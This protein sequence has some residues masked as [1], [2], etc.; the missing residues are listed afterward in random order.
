M[1]SIK[2][3]AIKGTLWT[4]GGYGTSQILRFASNL[5]LTRLLVPEYFGL[6]TIANTLRI[7]IELFSDIGIGQSIIQNKRGEEP[8]F[9]HTAWTLQ[10]LRGAMLWGICLLITWPAAQVYGDSRFLWM[11]PLIGLTS[12]I[13]GFTSMAYHILQRRMDL[14]RFT[15]FELLVQITSLSMMIL[16]AW[17][18]PSVLALVLGGVIGSVIRMVSSHLLLPGHKDRFA[19][20]RGALDDLV[21][22]GRWMFISTALMFLAEQADRLILGKLLSF[23]MLGIYS[24]AYTLANI[25]R[26]VIKHLSYRVLFAAISRQADLPRSELRAKIIKQR[27][28]ILLALAFM[29]AGLTTIGDQVIG[30]LY[31]HRYEPATWMM[32]I[33]CLGIWFSI[34]FYT[35]SPALLAIGKPLYSAQS[36][37]ARLIVIVIG[38]PTGFSIAGILGAVT[39]I[40]FS[41]LFP[42]TVILYGLWKE[43]LSCTL[44]DLQ[45]TALF[46]GILTGL[47]FLR[48]AIG[49]GLPIDNLLRGVGV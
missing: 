39:V 11:L 1:S 22:F 8:V 37:L 17:V 20:D 29:L 30:R 24:I 13:D 47:I 34:L 35:I 25:P 44:Q 41:D 28:F 9:L 3:L 33:L 4:F 40:A 43:K 2:K 27:Y 23:Q 31:D 49:F 48:Q 14:G 32:P 19:W 7:G 15:I 42:Y 46:A 12:L 10:I 5:I 38:L 26:E 16:I 21:S 18:Y 6:M 36:N 45:M